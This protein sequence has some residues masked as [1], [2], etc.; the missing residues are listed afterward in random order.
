MNLIWDEGN[1]NKSFAKHH[2]TD[3]EVEEIFMTGLAVA[4]GVQVEPIVTEE[5]V[6]VVGPTSER[7]MITVVFTLRDGRVRPISCRP[8]NRKERKLYET[9]RKIS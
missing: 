5:R 4:I 6:A 7:K 9:V 2:V 3:E 8:A 1:I